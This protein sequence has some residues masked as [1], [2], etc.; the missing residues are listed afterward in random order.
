MPSATKTE[1]K[2][3]STHDVTQH[4]DTRGETTTIKRD[5]HGNAEAIERPHRAEKHKPQNTNMTPTATLKA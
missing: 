1:W 4:D 2:Y 3:D 5:S